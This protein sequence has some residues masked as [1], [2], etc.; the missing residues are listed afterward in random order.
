MIKK[1][2]DQTLLKVKQN[3]IYFESYAYGMKEKFGRK[4]IVLNF[5]FEQY[6]QEC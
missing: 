6:V 4:Y 5:C 1:R 2:I 3:F